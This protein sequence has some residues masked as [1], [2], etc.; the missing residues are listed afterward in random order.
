MVRVVSGQPARLCL[1]FNCPWFHLLPSSLPQSL[2]TL[3]QAG[4]IVSQAREKTR[5]GRAEG[6]GWGGAQRL[7]E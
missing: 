6:A 7:G 3:P 1:P 2:R 4:D 5:G